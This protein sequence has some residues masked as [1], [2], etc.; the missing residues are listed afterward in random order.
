MT[1]KAIY[2]RSERIVD[3]HMCGVL[4]SGDAFYINALEAGFIDGEGNKRWG[5]L[6]P[7]PRAAMCETGRLGRLGREAEGQDR[8]GRGLPRASEAG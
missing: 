3:P 6:S 5:G 8:S 1:Y 4:M 7:L 2:A